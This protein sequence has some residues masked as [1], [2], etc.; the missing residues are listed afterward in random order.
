MKKYPSLFEQGQN[1]SKFALDLVK[2]IK[3]TGGKDLIASQELF[4]ER[5]EICYGC[6]KYDSEQNRCV[7]CGCFL[8]MKARFIL[9]SCPLKKWVEATDKWDDIFEEMMTEID[10][11]PSDE[12]TSD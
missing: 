1:L 5:M 10:E 2:H 9:D 3:H 6:D 12:K 4:D 7:E 8:D 11:K